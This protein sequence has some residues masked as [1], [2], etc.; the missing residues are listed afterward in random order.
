MSA[1]RRTLRAVL[2][3]VALR[4]LCASVALN[5]C[6]RDSKNKCTKCNS[7]ARGKN[8]G[9]RSGAHDVIYAT[10]V[11][12]TS[13]SGTSSPTVDGRLDDAVWRSAPLS[14]RYSNIPFARRDGTVVV[15][16]N[17]GAGTWEG[18][19]DF[20][21]TAM[22]AHDD[23]YLYLALEVT[24]DVFKVD[25]SCYKQGVQIGF[26][27][28]GRASQAADGRSLAGELQAKRASSLAVSRLDL[29]NFGLKPG[30]RECNTQPKPG[31]GAGGPAECCVH[32]EANRNADGWSK[33]TAAA[34]RRDER[35]KKTY[36]EAAFSK[37]D[38]LGRNFANLDRW[39]VGL[40]LGFAFLVNDGDESSQ[41]E[42]WGGYYPYALVRDWNRGEKRPDKA[43]V[44]QLDG[45]L[46][47]Q[48]RR[49]GGLVSGGGSGWVS[50]LAG[51]LCTAVV[52]VAVP[53]ALP[54][55]AHG[56]T[57]GARQLVGAGSQQ[58]HA[59]YAR[60]GDEGAG[61]GGSVNGMNSGGGEPVQMSLR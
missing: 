60:M 40:R 28:G 47:E 38:L 50:F 51:A 34:A 7:C 6:V 35:H 44:L 45:T 27:T 5:P 26:E 32:Y 11:G 42:G 4:F 12:G 52:A 2:A 46:E 43:G 8:D 56:L 54:A 39:R 21:Y 15:F 19:Q 41:Q 31:L 1:R 22:L 18:T 33:L 36:Y 20:G 53:S 14:R 24:D 58:A 57:R 59:N 3:V 30:Q 23:D 17:E 25:A 29:L 9:W 13:G 16:E 37:I 10:R 49:S 48:Q 61:Q 55:A